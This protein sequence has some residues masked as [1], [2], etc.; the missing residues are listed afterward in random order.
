M[1]AKKIVAATGNKG[2]LKEFKEILSEFEIISVNDL[3]LNLN[4]SENGKTFKENAYIKAKA[5]SKFTNL[6]VLSDDSGLMVDALGGNPGVFTARFAGEN[7]TDEENI[8]KLLYEL[9]GVD[10]DK[11]TARFMSAICV[12]LPDKSV[13]YGEGTCEGSICRSPVGANGFGY[14]PVFFVDE[15]KKTFAE[16]TSDEKNSVSHRRKALDDISQKLKEFFDVF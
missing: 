9:S 3:N 12:I 1:Y 15:F 6:P 2:K 7:A 14:D 13:L 5:I 8:N 11:R 16:L 4:I 10:D